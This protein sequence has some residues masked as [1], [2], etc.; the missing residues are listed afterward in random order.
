MKCHRG[1]GYRIPM[2]PITVEMVVD[3]GKKEEKGISEE[4]TYDNEGQ[5]TGTLK[6]PCEYPLNKT[7]NQALSLKVSMKKFAEVARELRWVSM[8]ENADTE[9]TSWANGRRAMKNELI[10]HG[11]LN[12]R[13][14]IKKLY[15]EAKLAEKLGYIKKEDIQLDVEK[16][17]AI[18]REH[19]TWFRADRKEKGITNIAESICKASK[20]VVK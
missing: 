9:M 14:Y 12:H 8:E 7:F 2:K 1:Y 15:E 13:E 20:G 19:Y 4:K 3:E 10:T 5:Y 18:I 16:I 17:K 11:W 6:I